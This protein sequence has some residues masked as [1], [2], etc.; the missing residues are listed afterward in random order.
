ML[1]IGSL[2]WTPYIY[3]GTCIVA[4]LNKNWRIS[5]MLPGWPRRQAWTQRRRRRRRRQRRGRRTKK[6]AN[7]DIPRVRVFGLD[8][9][10]ST[11]L[12]QYNEQVSNG[13][14]LRNRTVLTIDTSVKLNTFPMHRYHNTRL[15]LISSYI[16]HLTNHIG[17][18][19]VMNFQHRIVWHLWD[20]V[21]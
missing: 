1:L 17:M 9:C 8:C 3:T 4:A 11:C 16:V 19:N 7:N 21:C 13:D 2:C 18:D 5:S 14:S 10:I 15:R 20:Y 6:S 12:K